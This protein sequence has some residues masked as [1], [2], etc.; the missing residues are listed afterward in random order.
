MVVLTL[1]AI[2]LGYRV[3]TVGQ[4]ERAA[5]EIQRNSIGLLVRRGDPANPSPSLRPY[6]MQVLIGPQ[7]IDRIRGVWI[8][9]CD[10]KMKGVRDNSRD[11]GDKLILPLVAHMKNLPYMTELA[12]EGVPITSVTVKSVAELHNLESLAISD[13]D[14]DDNAVPYILSMKNLTYLSIGGTN[15]SGDGRKRLKDGLPDCE[16]F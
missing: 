15:I 3:T 10:N 9:E 12:I 4:I 5:T 13:T 1:F 14:V 6:W 2:W 8:R 7:Q 16:M 11:W